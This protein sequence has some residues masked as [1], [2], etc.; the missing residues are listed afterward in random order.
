MTLLDLTRSIVKSL[1][2]T[3]A[4]SVAT[5]SFRLCSPLTAE[6]DLPSTTRGNRYKKRRK[7]LFAINSICITCRRIRKRRV[8]HVISHVIGNTKG[9]KMSVRNVLTRRLPRG[10]RFKECSLPSYP[11][12][13][14]PSESINSPC[15][16]AISLAIKE[17]EYG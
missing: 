1:E 15:V 17:P 6:Y 10:G 5:D 2:G 4:K 14:Y 11:R 8:W 7:D 3:V 12:H 13:L 16:Q 9:G